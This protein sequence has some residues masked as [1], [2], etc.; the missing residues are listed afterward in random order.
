MLPASVDGPPLHHYE[1]LLAEQTNNNYLNILLLLNGE[2]NT[3][4]QDIVHVNVENILAALA[5]V[6]RTWYKTDTS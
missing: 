2:S 3:L 6:S 4:T 5:Q 1:P